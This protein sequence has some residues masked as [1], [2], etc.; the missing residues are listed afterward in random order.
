M[1]V[2]I[3][4]QDKGDLHVMHLDLCCGNCDVCKISVVLQIAKIIMTVEIL[5][6]VSHKLDHL[7]N[8]IYHGRIISIIIIRPCIYR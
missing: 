3:L 2:L 5:H 1:L 7:L 4:Q 8:Y 6:Q